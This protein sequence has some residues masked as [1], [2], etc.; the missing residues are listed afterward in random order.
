MTSLRV[1]LYTTAVMLLHVSAGKEHFY[2]ITIAITTMITVNVTLTLT[3]TR[4]MTLTWDMILNYGCD[5]EPAYTM[6]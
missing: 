6:I 5:Q 1:L 3:M 4:A 2:Y